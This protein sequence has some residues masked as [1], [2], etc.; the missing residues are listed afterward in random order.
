MKVEG[1][2]VLDTSNNTISIKLE[3]GSYAQMLFPNGI[4]TWLEVELECIEE[5]EARKNA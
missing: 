5:T 3:N 2:I 1:K 4:K